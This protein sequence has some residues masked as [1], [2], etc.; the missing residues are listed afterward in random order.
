MQYDNLKKK[1]IELLIGN[2]WPFSFASQMP[3]DLK[4]LF[5]D[6]AD[7]ICCLKARI[8]QME[9]KMARIH[10][11]FSGFPYEFQNEE[12]DEEVRS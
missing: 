4:Q 3:N 5:I 10:P 11:N 7:E 1:A 12:D 2:A 6:M 9:K 8:D